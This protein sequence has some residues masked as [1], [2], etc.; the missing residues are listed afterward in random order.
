MTCKFV[1]ETDD[2]GVWLHEPACD[3]LAHEGCSSD[4]NCTINQVTTRRN[5]SDEIGEPGWQAIDHLPNCA[6]FH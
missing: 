4:C 6:Q 5:G 3:A 1:M 2:E